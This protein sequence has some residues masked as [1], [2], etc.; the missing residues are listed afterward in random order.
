MD[1]NRVHIRMLI[2]RR[3]SFRR[4]RHS[5]PTSRW[6]LQNTVGW[7]PRV[8]SWLN[9]EKGLETPCGGS[10]VCSGVC[11]PRSVF[12]LSLTLTGIG[13][14]DVSRSG[15]LGLNIALALVLQESMGQLHG[16]GTTSRLA[17][18]HASAIA[19]ALAPS[20][21]SRGHTHLKSSYGWL[22][23]AIEP[24]IVHWSNRR[25]FVRVWPAAHVSRATEDR[26]GCCY[27][28][29]AHQ[30]AQQ[31]CGLLMGGPATRS[32]IGFRLAPGPAGVQCRDSRPP[33]QTMK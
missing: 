5:R 28:C 19:S 31:G 13:R 18:D 9:D 6:E 20:I 7:M 32:I 4:T 8:H 30:T 17:G 1:I 21:T 11:R 10:G 26:H 12:S 27:L 23:L 33:T 25:S 29:C 15:L 14:S 3:A 2:P 24:I 16:V 22:L